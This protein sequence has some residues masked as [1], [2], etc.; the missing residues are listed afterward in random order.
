MLKNASYFAFTATP[1]NKTLETF[2]TKTPKVSL[3]PFD[4]YTM[5]QAIE[6]EFILDVL[7]NYTTYQ[8]YYK[9]NKA[10][11]DNPEFETHQA[12]EK[13]K[14]LCRKPSI[15]HNGEIKSDD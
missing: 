3:Y 9:L 2:G 8:S 10:V 13:I 7:K 14:G 11:E 15:L 6:E 4:A 12:I 1:K 5:K